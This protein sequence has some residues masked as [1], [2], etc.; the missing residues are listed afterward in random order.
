MTNKQVIHRSIIRKIDGSTTLTT[1][2]CGRMN[3]HLADGWNV[4]K[5]VTCKHCL[6][7]M[8]QEW[9]KALIAKS[10]V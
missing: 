3:N 9:G 1:T 7:A 10:E 2:L 6:N 5:N 4:G 8:K